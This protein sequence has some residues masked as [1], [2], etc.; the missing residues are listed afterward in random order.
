[1]TRWLTPAF[2]FGSIASET[3]GGMLWKSPTH[4]LPSQSSG[5]TNNGYNP[6]NMA[7]DF[8]SQCTGVTIDKESCL[9]STTLATIMGEEY[10]GGDQANDEDCNPPDVSEEVLLVIM[11]DSRAQCTAITDQSISDQE[12]TTTKNAFHSMLTDNSCILQMCQEFENP[13]SPEFMEIVIAEAARCAGV[14]LTADECIRSSIVEFFSAEVS[15][16]QEGQAR[17][18]ESLQDDSYCESPPSELELTMGAAYIVE[19]VKSQCPNTLSSTEF[20]AT[21]ADL[22]TLLRSPQ[23]FGQP[24]CDDNAV[25]AQDDTFL[26]DDSNDGMDLLSIGMKFVE[27]CAGIELDRD[28]CIVSTIFDMM[29]S[30]DMSRRRF[31]Q[32][33]EESCDAPDIGDEILIAMLAGARGQCLYKS[34]EYTEEEYEEKRAQVFGFFGAES[35]WIDLCEEFMNPSE[36]FMMLFFEEVADCAGAQLDLV[37]QC[38]V[39][40]V[41]DL[42]FSLEAENNTDVV[43]ADM[44]Q[45]VLRVLSHNETEVSTQCETPSEDEVGPFVGLL[46]VTIEQNCTASGELIGQ[47]ELEMAY[48]ELLKLFIAPPQCWGGDAGDCE[49]QSQNDDYDEDNEDNGLNHIDIAIKFV[50]ECS[51]IDLD[52][53]DCFTAHSLEMLSSGQDMSRRR[54]LEHSDDSYSCNDASPGFSEETLLSVF[55]S[56]RQMCSSYSIEYT[57]E[58]YEQRS[59]KLLDIFDADNCFIS[60]CK[61]TINPTETYLTIFFEVAAECAGIES[62]IV[63]QC[64]WDHVIDT[65][66][67]SMME[68]ESDGPDLLRRKLSHESVDDTCYKPSE[69]EIAWFVTPVLMEAGHSCAQLG[70]EFGQAEIDTVYNEFVKLVTAPPKCLG[71]LASSPCSEGGVDKKSQDEIDSKFV[72]HVQEIAF[73]ALMSCS[74]VVETCVMKKSMEILL[75]NVDSCAPPVIEDLDIEEIADKAVSWCT[76]DRQNNDHQQAI[77]DMMQLMTKSECWKGVCQDEEF[78]NYVHSSWMGTCSFTDSKFMFS[79]LDSTMTDSGLSLSNDKLKCMADYILEAKAYGDGSH[80]CSVLQ[81]GP[82]V[83]GSDFDLGL[84]AYMSCSDDI[85]YTEHPTPSPMSEEFSMSYSFEDPFEWAGGFQAPSELPED[86]EFLSYDMSFSYSFDDLIGHS[87]SYDY[88]PPS[89]HEELAQSYVLEVCHLLESLQYN[90]AAR[91]CMEPICDLGI[92]GALLYILEANETTYASQ[93]ESSGAPS[94]ELSHAPS[95]SPV[96]PSLSPS[97]SPTAKPTEAPTKKPTSAPTFSPTKA[98]FGSVDVKFE[99]AVTLGGINVTDLDFTALGEVIALLEKVLASAIPEGALVRLLK[100]GGVSVSRRMLRE[101]QNDEEGVEVEFEVI[102]TE[103]CD[104]AECSNS[105]DISAAAYKEVTGE[106]QKKVQD[107]SLSTAIQEEADAEGISELANV[108][109]KPDSLKASGPQ[110]TVKKADPET[111]DTTDDDDSSST[112]F[113]STIALAVVSVAVFFGDF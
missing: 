1:M 15:N 35:C 92:E 103:T 39:D 66:V 96:L 51:G 42:M 45:R 18:L 60:L 48:N 109:V 25:M 38:L 55:A 24:P 5:E 4:F 101:L 46:L 70:E 43:G 91:D 9:V 52:M 6:A 21:V 111:D 113:Q 49:D 87:M 67:S 44:S 108:S 57:T 85:V 75:G 90:L 84:Q 3:T 88:E 65:A 94:I 106:L 30:Q 80:E 99:A 26:G 14:E 11:T 81:L 50:E 62:E 12:F 27:Q 23:C 68:G 105:E 63:N 33:G 76:N 77:H 100:I 72:E 19:G 98:K 53:D 93:I 82:N 13:S 47:S 86:M 95:T 56:A 31:L 110:V 102:I 32:Q 29:A 7:L 58:E 64:L 69:A 2:A 104:D 71:E 36:A 16:S 79:S 59:S 89:P 22:V 37:N 8:L 61:E 112:A 78:K 17:L 74:N 107:G 73:G 41:L 54:Y 34:I 83:C 97:A 28:D 40:G 10:E 20:D